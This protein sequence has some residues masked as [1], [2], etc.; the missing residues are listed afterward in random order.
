MD[1]QML[2]QAIQWCLCSPLESH[3]KLAITPFI[4]EIPVLGGDRTAKV[5]IGIGERTDFKRVSLPPKERN[6]AFHPSILFLI[7]IS[8]SLKYDVFLLPLKIGASKYTIGDS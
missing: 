7:F 6:L 3:N 4:L 2:S 1:L 5:C 8:K